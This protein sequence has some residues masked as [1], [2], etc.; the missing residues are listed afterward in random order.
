MF[1]R[2]NVV[3]LVVAFFV[4]LLAGGAVGMLHQPKQLGPSPNQ[5]IVTKDAHYPP[6]VQ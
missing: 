1:T 3:A 5:V 6:V 2:R 4:A